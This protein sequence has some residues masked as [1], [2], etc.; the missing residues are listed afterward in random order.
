MER[1]Q[2]SRDFLSYFPYTKSPISI[3]DD[4]K[5]RHVNEQNKMELVLDTVGIK[6]LSISHENF[7]SEWS[8]APV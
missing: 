2:I 1:A 3:F 8:K 6:R 4:K 7:P 5:L